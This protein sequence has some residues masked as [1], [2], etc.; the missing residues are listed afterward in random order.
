M[1][2]GEKIG[3]YILI[4]KPLRRDGQAHTLGFF[5]PQL[6]QIAINALHILGGFPHV[7]KG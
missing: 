7:H 5:V 4:P 3:P 6:T 1:I 2:R